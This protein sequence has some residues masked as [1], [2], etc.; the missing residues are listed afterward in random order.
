[1]NIFVF[2][3]LLLLYKVSFI[4]FYFLGVEEQFEKWSK[5]IEIHQ[6]Y[7]NKE[8]NIIIYYFKNWSFLCL[9]LIYKSGLHVNGINI[10]SE[11]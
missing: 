9:I 8:E 4:I 5:N 7:W 10:Q 11:S 3:C 2:F 6:D 1:M